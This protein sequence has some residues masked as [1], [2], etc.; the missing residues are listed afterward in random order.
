MNPKLTKHSHFSSKTQ[1]VEI[2]SGNLDRL[3]KMSLH[4]QRKEL[5]NF[6]KERFTQKV[7]WNNDKKNKH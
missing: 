3:I 7:I 6:I 5:E 4:E 1:I 2:D